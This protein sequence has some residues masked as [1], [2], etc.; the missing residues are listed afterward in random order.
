MQYLKRV[1]SLILLV[2]LA[3][4]NNWIGPKVSTS[5]SVYTILFCV[6]NMLLVLVIIVAYNLSRSITK[7]SIVVII[8]SIILIILFL[9]SFLLQIDTV[10]DNTIINQLKLLPNNM[11]FI[12]YMQLIFGYWTITYILILKSVHVRRGNVISSIRYMGP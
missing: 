6:M 2:S 8:D 1:L 10:L 7:N 12:Y 5:F 9:L 11:N 4:M 3:L